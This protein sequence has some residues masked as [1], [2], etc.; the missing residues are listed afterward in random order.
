[1]PISAVGRSISWGEAY[2]LTQQLATDPA[3]RVGAAINGW[4]FPVSREVLVLMDLFDLTHQI[5][6]R[7]GGS[8]GARPKPY[9]RP[10][11]G[12]R[13][14]RPRPTISQSAVMEALRAA[15]HTA[16]A[17]KWARTA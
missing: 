7:Q 6:W 1:M 9:P 5:A 4:E 12:K 17:P 16:P 11:R 8:K 13:K 10:M 3:S 2:R 14:T 15:G